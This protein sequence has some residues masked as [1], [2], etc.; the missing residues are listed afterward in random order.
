MHAR[1]TGWYPNRV[2]VIFI[3]FQ[4]ED[5][6]GVKEEVTKVL[7]KLIVYLVLVYLQTSVVANL[8]SG[9]GRKSDSGSLQVVTG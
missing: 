3:L 9:G 2:S 1:Q 5:D 8:V 7:L 6:A 4:G